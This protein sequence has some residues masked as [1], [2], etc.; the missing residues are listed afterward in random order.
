MAGP[1]EAVSDFI[2]RDAESPTAARLANV[3]GN[4]CLTSSPT[5]S[6]KLSTSGCS[7]GSS[8]ESRESFV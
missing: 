7:S 6:G 2:T 1:A 4:G 5:Y 3:S 8:S